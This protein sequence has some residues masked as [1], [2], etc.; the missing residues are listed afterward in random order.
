MRA[1]PM[2]VV[3][4]SSLTESGCA[5]TLRALEL[6]AVDFV[7]KPKLDLRERMPEVAQEVI[8][9]VKAAAMARVRTR[10]TLTGAAPVRV[11][12]A[13]PRGAAHDAAGARGGRV[14]RRH[15]GAPGVPHRAPRRLRPAS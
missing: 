5:T 2:P 10:P 4:V 9:K 6:G 12:P 15:R 13:R 11:R 8:E 1:H 3:M 7:T 14:D